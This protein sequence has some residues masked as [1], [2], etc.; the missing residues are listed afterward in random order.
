MDLKQLREYLEILSTS[1]NEKDRKVLRARLKSLISV[2]PF[3]EYEYIFRIFTFNHVEGGVK[4][5]NSD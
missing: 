5:G 4:H 2:F 1:L 3:N